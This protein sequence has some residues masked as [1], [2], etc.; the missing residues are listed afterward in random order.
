MHKRLMLRF[1]HN[2]MEILNIASRN[3]DKA[4]SDLFMTDGIYDNDPFNVCLFI[5]TQTIHHAKTI[6]IFFSFSH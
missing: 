2:Q 6:D 4:Y 5:Y 3:A 1:Q